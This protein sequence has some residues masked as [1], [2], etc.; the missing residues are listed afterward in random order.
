ML[1]LFSG[2]LAPGANSPST[3]EYKAT[4]T[5]VL[6]EEEIL[7]D[8]S[9]SAVGISYFVVS[10]DG[11][12][13]AFKISYGDYHLYVM[14]P[15]GSGLTV[16]DASFPADVDSASDPELNQD[17]TR[18]F[19]YGS[20][21]LTSDLD[22][23]YYDIAAG[24][25][26]FA[27]TFDL[28]SA[29]KP[30]AIND[31]GTRLFA[32]HSGDRD[33][34][35]EQYQRG[36]FY[37]DVGGSP[38]QVLDWTE[39]PCNQSDCG[40]WY[41]NLYFLG[42]S[43]NGNTLLFKWDA[44]GSSGDTEAMYHTDLSGSFVQAPSQTN[45]YVWDVGDPE[46]LSMV[47][48]DGSKA[49]YIGKDSGELEELSVVDLTTGQKTVIARSG[50]INYATISSDGAFARFLGDSSYK[51]HTLV[52]LST[53]KMRDTLSTYI[54]V[55]ATGNTFRVTDLTS[56]NR[57]FFARIKEDDLDRMLRVDLSP[58]DFSITPDVTSVAFSSPM[59]INDGST[60]I[61]VYA[62]VSD[63]QGLST[64]EWVK[65][66]SLVEGLEQTDYSQE[67]P[68]WSNTEPLYY[69]SSLYDDGTHGDQVAG[70]GVYTV[71]DL[72]TRTSS[73]F[74]D[75]YSLPHDVGIRIVAKDAD[76]NYL[77]ADGVLT[78]TDT[79]SSNDPPS[80]PVL[81]TP[82]DGATGVSLTAELRTRAFSDPDS[83]DTHLQTEWQVS[84]MNDFS[85]LTL[86][87]TST[88]RLV[89]LTV[90]RF[91]LE[92][93]TV[94]YWR[95]RFYDNNS[96][97]SDW[98]ETYSFTTLTTTNDQ[99][100]NGI[101]D[102]LE[103]STADLDNDGTADAEQNDISSLNTAIGDGQI[104]VSRRDDPTV[105]TIN[106]IDSIDPDTVSLVARPSN[107]TL[108]L[109]AIRLTVANAGDRAQVTIY[110][111]QAAPIQAKWYMYDP[112]S[113]WVDFSSYATF[114]SDR[115]SVTLDLK[116][117]DYG[118]AD[119]IANGV[120]V[121][122]GAFGVASWIQ[123]AVTDT[124]TSQG[125][126][127]AVVTLGSIS[128][129]TNQNGN[130]LTIIPPGTYSATITASGYDSLGQ[131]GVQI[132]EAAIETQNFSL[133]AGNGTG[134]I[135]MNRLAV[136]QR[137]TPQ[138]GDALEFTAV[139]TNPGGG[140]TYYRFDLIPNYGTNDYDAATN[141]QTI[142]EFSAAITCRKT[143]DTAG[144]YV[145]VAWASTTASIPTGAA[146]IIGASFTIGG[147]AG[148]GIT[149]L[150]MSPARTIQAGESVT[151]TA[152]G[153]NA[154]TGDIYYRFDLIPNYGTSSYD[155]NNNY[156]TIQSFSTANTCTHTF[157]EAGS[158]VI[159]VWASSTA[160]FPTD[161][162]P[163][164]IGGSITVQ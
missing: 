146:P 135:G 108:G 33:P 164:I 70:D 40:I 31:S 68:D 112:I 102:D 26:H 55:I 20:P 11:S 99:N 153:V 24:T 156:Q 95:V 64:I 118:D 94:Y 50:S 45:R 85:S 137:A 115:K 51:E 155:P 152:S 73:G 159:V 126:A 32:R 83:G 119:G 2:R 92:E 121:D 74:F 150:D 96:N 122:P 58:D 114:S 93:G 66:H 120:I 63:A 158:Y 139:A 148:V 130:Y 111:S 13:T 17:G 97:A 81:I 145:V 22:F 47:T 59:L 18:L 78:I 4:L 107:M 53:G 29:K 36:L 133:S 90:P 136:N 89:T 138:V 3:I 113:G 144:G 56:D 162:P 15:D 134:S 60:A 147:S 30:Y 149:S 86:D 129:Q 72:K 54:P 12:K 27:A 101:P 128:I 109:V 104:G 106:S 46:V 6:N 100:G 161:I 75:K 19:F 37:A 34:V 41:N 21:G 38:V 123:G 98:S 77:I 140:E 44:N 91:V 131:S 69:S 9:A 14:N 151:F 127:N 124:S 143:F 52:D 49:L 62:T 87:T 10:G 8:N 76:D 82:A 42:C 35:T 116:D 132:Q 103:N 5:N 7:G 163:P 71:D 117:G 16:V 141:W 154:T 23:Y 80:P 39:L 65:M 48:A 79:L 125:I 142:Q 157:S 57:Y 25:S 160:A 84:K 110:F 28:T 67:N 43:A 1:L 105:T 88:S 61:T